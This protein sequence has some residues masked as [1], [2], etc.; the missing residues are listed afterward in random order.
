QA[1]ALAAASLKMST[2]ASSSPLSPEPLI[3]GM[4]GGGTVGGGVYE[5]C[6]KKKQL[7]ESLGANI[8]IK[9]ICVKDAT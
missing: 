9:K 6:Q 7:F 2:D 5:I 1:R 8:K 3:V 4:F